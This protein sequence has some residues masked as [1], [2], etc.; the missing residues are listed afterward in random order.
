MQVSCLVAL[1]DSIVSALTG[2]IQENV[3]QLHIYLKRFFDGKNRSKLWQVPANRFLSLSFSLA[4]YEAP[5]SQAPITY[6]YCT[7]DQRWGGWSW[8]A[9]LPF[10]LLSTSHNDAHVHVPIIIIYAIIACTR[11][12]NS[13]AYEE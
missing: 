11:E 2:T 10:F 5:T 9:G 8:L 6:Q 4:S 7:S 3:D 13:C 1:V 12:K